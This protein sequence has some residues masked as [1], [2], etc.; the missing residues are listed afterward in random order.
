MLN[1]E[2]QQVDLLENMSLVKYFFRVD[3]CD[4]E[5]R[6]N[7]DVQ[8]GPA[9]WMAKIDL[10]DIYSK[11]P[12]NIRLESV[13]FGRTLLVEAYLAVREQLSNTSNKNI[14][15][16]SHQNMS[17]FRFLSCKYACVLDCHQWLPPLE[18]SVILWKIW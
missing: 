6:A 17:N 10:A 16:K 9:S 11:L 4:A 3:S 2:L 13:E 18:K 8:D 1:E 15:T 5:E 14:L 7:C 12:L